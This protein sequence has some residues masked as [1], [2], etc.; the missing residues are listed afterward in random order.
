VWTVSEWRDLLRR[1]TDLALD[2]LEVG[3]DVPITQPV[4]AD[5]LMAALGGPLPDAPSDPADVIEDLARALAPGLVRTN[6]GRYFGFV[7]GG[8]LP[9]ALA[10]DWLASTY[11]QNPAFFVLSPAVAVVEEVCARWLREVL[12]LPASASVGFTTGAQMANLAGLAAAR[13]HVLRQAGWDVDADGLLG[14]PELTVVVGEERHATVG[15]A[16]R[17]LGLQDIVPP[18]NSR[19]SFRVRRLRCSRTSFRFRRWPG[20]PP[21]W[22]RPRRNDERGRAAP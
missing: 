12:G 10:A 20:L 7:E 4:D 19:T 1:T 18:L 13:G 5:H 22:P 16:L 9:A 8:V 15:R 2:H 3:D 14:A 21:W 11:D 17:L 6:A